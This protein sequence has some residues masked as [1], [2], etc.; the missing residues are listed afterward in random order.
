MAFAHAIPA[1][2]VA[3]ATDPANTVLLGETVHQTAIPVGHS[4][5]FSWL[6]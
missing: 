4:W 3:V 1:A 2:C 5:S 6:N